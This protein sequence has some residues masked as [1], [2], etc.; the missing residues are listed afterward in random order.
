MKHSIFDAPLMVNQTFSKTQINWQIR[1]CSYYAFSLNQISD[2]CEVWK[3]YSLKV[4]F[5]L[6]S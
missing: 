4:G 5:C 2:I 1:F 3:Y 6:I